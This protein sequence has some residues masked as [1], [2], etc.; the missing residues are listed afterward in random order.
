MKR[1]PRAKEYRVFMVLG[2]KGEELLYFS[3]G[4]GPVFSM[5]WY[6][7]RKTKDAYVAIAGFPIKCCQD[8]EDDEIPTPRRGP[9]L[10]SSRRLVRH[11]LLHHR[12]HRTLLPWW[13]SDSKLVETNVKR[14][15]RSP[16][17]EAT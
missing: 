11:F 13:D 15:A 10:A 16:T 2:P 6:P 9:T 14:L 12:R 3:D 4:G 8:C 5:V 1:K 17:T 7:Y